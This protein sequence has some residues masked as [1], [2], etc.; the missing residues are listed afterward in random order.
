MRK[1]VFTAFILLLT[2][3]AHADD[4]VWEQ[5][6]SV[7]DKQEDGSANAIDAKIERVDLDGLKVTYTTVEDGEDPVTKT[8]KICTQDRAVNGKF[9]TESDR[10][11]AI[12]FRVH[13]FREAKKA[14][15]VI[16]VGVRGPWSPCVYPL[17]I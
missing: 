1:L 2:T 9:Y 10:S 4:S 14:Q 8:S 6:D 5:Q 16:K 17:E 7:W 13:K 3:A 15:D 12:G 11:L